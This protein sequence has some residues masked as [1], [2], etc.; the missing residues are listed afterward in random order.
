MT[1]LLVLLG[2][3]AGAA[4]CLT[5]LSHERRDDMAGVATVL[6]VADTGVVMSERPIVRLQLRVELPGVAPYDTAASA[7]VPEAAVGFVRPGA[8]VGVLVDPT[9]LATVSVDLS[10]LS[11]TAAAAAAVAA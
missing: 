1:A 10:R 6:D 2:A 9:D 7:T 3:L 5:R 11:V 4:Y 8:R